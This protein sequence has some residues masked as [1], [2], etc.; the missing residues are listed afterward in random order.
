MMSSA[1]DGFAF[2]AEIEL[3]TLSEPIRDDTAVTK[4]GYWL[5]MVVD[6][7]EDRQ[8]E[9]D[10]RDLLKGKLLNEWVSGLWDNAEIDDSYLDDEKKWWAIM[11]ATGS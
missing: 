9:D 2:D 8:L 10:G 11:Q 6:K 1:F 4:G 5:I 7:D 3:E